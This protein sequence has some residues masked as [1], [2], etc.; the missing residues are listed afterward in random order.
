MDQGNVD[1]GRRAERQHPAHLVHVLRGLA[2]ALR[3]VLPDE[4][5]QAHDGAADP[6]EDADPVDAGFEP[7][8]A[9]FG[10][11]E[12]GRDVDVAAAGDEVVEDDDLRC[13]SC[14]LKR[15]DVCTYSAERGHEDVITP[16]KR[17]KRR[18]VR[19]QLPWQHH[20]PQNRTHNLAPPDSQI[21]RKQPRHIRPKW[22]RVRAKV[23]RKHAQNETERHKEHAR[24]PRR[25]PVV[26]QNRVQQIPQVPVGLPPGALQGR[27]G[28]Q[29]EEEDEALR[30]EHA[31]ALQPAGVGGAAGVAREVGLVDEHGR[32][33]AHDDV[34]AVH[35]GP[36]EGDGRGGFGGGGGVDV[37]DAGAVG[38]APPEEPEAGEGHDEAFYGED[39][40]D[41]RGVDPSLEGC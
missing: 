29:P 40:V 2:D 7:V 19:N 33:G 1:D 18:R 22:D 25:R 28:G 35:D 9:G 27:R 37:G 4:P 26:V 15:M 13:V 31:G 16:Q 36:A 14:A 23:R 5:R 39:V 41:V 20:N 21:P 10:A 6:R 3:L 12:E 17:K 34:D 32:E 11:I 24:P 30:E 38:H 8:E